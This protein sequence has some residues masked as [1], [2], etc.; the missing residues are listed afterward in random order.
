M[1]DTQVQLVN[2]KAAVVLL[3]LVLAYYWAIRVPEEKLDRS[4]PFYTAEQVRTHN[5]ADDL[6]IVLGNKVYDVTQFVKQHP[7]GDA[8]LAVPGGNATIAFY[9]HGHS[10]YAVSIKDLYVIG[11]MIPGSLPVPL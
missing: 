8:I 7:G 1:V 5:T 10:D 2:V 4:M 9:G 3:V 6:W 11:H